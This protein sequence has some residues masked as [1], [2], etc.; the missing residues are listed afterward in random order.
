[1]EVAPCLSACGLLV[2]LD[3][4][5]GDLGAGELRRRR[6]AVAEHLADLRAAEEEAILGVVRAGLVGA[7]ALALVTPERVLELERTDAEL[8]DVDLV[9]DRLGV[10]GAVVVADAGVVAADD[11]MGRAVVA[12]DERVED[13]LARTGVAHR[14]RVDAEHDAVMRVVVVHQD[15]VALHP[16]VGGDVALLG[17]ADQ[18]VQEE[19]VADLE[20][21]LRQVL[22]GAMDRVAGLEG[23]DP[24][25]AAIGELLARLGGREVAAHERL[26]V[27][28]GRVGLDLAGDAAVALLLGGGD[29]RMSVV[30]G[31]VDVLGLLLDVALEDLADP[32]PA[33]GLAVVGAERDD[34][35]LADLEVGGERHR[36]R[37]DLLTV[38][39]GH[40]L[41]ARLPV[42]GAHESLQRGEAAVGEQLEVGGLAGG[43]GQGL[44]AHGFVV[45][46]KV[47]FRES[48][49]FGFGRGRTGK[50]QAKPLRGQPCRP[51][52]VLW[53]SAHRP[54][55]EFPSAPGGR[56]QWVQPIDGKPAS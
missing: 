54:E 55:R 37:P 43:K 1:M 38:G 47:G 40:V 51:H 18:R 8:V 20:R 13:R 23:D 22:V 26:F 27:V 42:G 10:V 4:D 33:E 46:L 12:A 15:L 45:L 16:H 32:D 19:A 24:L 5:L 30:G 39:Q 53:A 52:S 11:E 17:L 56:V 41:D 21:R 6:L 7:H 35:A 28:G 48:N 49:P 14:R 9:E 25:P 50:L 31:P 44:V 34:V 3:Q 29:S 2:G 36:D